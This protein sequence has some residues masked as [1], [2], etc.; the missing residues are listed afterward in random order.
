[1]KPIDVDGDMMMGWWRV[2]PATGRTLGHGVSGWGE[3]T[4]SYSIDLSV[5]T[6]MQRAVYMLYARG[7]EL[8]ARGAVF[9][10]KNAV[11]MEALCAMCTGVT[12][13]VVSDPVLSDACTVYCDAFGP[14]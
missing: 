8:A 5:A 6:R 14:G 3:E 11:W 1:M 10:S 2:D 9:A 12:M 13:F 7:G 4:T